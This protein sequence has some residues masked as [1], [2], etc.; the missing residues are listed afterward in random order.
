MRSQAFA[1]KWE[2]REI[3]DS[4]RADMFWVAMLLPLTQTGWPLDPLAKPSSGTKRR[5]RECS[6]AP[7]RVCSSSR[8][9]G[10]VGTRHPTT[11]TRSPSTATTL[12]NFEVIPLFILTVLQMYRI[13]Q[14]DH[15]GRGPWKVSTAAYVYAVEAGESISGVDS[16]R[17]R[18]IVAF[19]WQPQQRDGV[20]H[21]H[22]HVGECATGSS[23]SIGQQLLL[24][25]RFPTGRFALGVVIRLA[26]VEFGVRPL[27]HDWEDVF[28]QPRAAEEQWKTW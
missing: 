24:K 18:E 17:R 28:D 14:T 8:V 27:W 10:T 2:A 21:P 20:T 4:D 26:I 5:R 9:R 22:L 15:P 23:V 7:R 19:H 1:G 25:L 11:R 13:V 6:P 16:C 12:R 3:P